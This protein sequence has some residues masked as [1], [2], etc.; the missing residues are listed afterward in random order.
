MKG[1][2]SLPLAL[3]PYAGIILVLTNPG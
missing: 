1:R 3:V 2:H